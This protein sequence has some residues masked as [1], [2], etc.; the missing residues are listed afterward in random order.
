MS[1]IS[2]LVGLEGEFGGGLCVVVVVGD[3]DSDIEE[4]E[5]IVKGAFFVILKEIVFVMGSLG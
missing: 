2:A 1:T 3:G 4:R 5:G